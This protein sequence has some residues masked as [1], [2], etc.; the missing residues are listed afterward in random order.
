MK[1]R[2]FMAGSATG[3][4]A[5]RALRRIGY[6]GALSVELFDPVV[7]NSDPAVVARTCYA[8]VTRFTSAP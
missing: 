8:A 2:Q 6:A 1:R 4:V 7:Q 3:V 5:L